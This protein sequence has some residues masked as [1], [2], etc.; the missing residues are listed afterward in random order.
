MH[1][2]TQ[3]GAFLASYVSERFN[4]LAYLGHILID[5]EGAYQPIGGT[6]N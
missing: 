4:W 6:C 1:F 3:Y 5:S 2:E